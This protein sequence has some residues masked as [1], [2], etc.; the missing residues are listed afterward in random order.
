MLQ[1]SIVLFRYIVHLCLTLYAPRATFVQRTATQAYA[2]Y[3][4]M[5]DLTEKLVSGA[6]MSVLGTTIVSSGDA[7]GAS[8]GIDL[9]APWRRVTMSDL[10]KDK[11]GELGFV[12]RNGCS[13]GEEDLMGRRLLE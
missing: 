8:P 5:M 11:T 3:F 1:S 6:A 7:D 9:K 2:D 4:D 13:G 12:L 10:V